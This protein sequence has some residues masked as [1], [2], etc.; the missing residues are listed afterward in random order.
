MPR[1]QFIIRPDHDG[2]AKILQRNG[3][4]NLTS[5]RAAHPNT[6]AS[7][8]RQRNRQFMENHHGKS[9]T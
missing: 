9:T 5:R 8:S 7:V 3:R 4:K 2:L 1:Q 6:S